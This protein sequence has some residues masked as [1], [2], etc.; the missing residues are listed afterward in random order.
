M[1]RPSRDQYYAEMVAVAAKR[2]TCPRR[3]VGAIVVDERGVVLGVGHNGVPRNVPHCGDR[4]SYC[5]AQDAAPGVTSACWAVHAEVNALLQCSDVE[6][7]HT[8]YVSATPCFAC[9]KVIANTA[10]K[11]VVALEDYREPAPSGWL[12]LKSLG[13]S[14][15]IY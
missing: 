15:E 5:L 1:D 8:M 3:A 2:S 14:C 7:A 12:V 10:I 13:I 9:A 11:R 4:G 6:R